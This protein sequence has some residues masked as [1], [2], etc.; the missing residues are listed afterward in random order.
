MNALA[1]ILQGIPLRAPYYPGTIERFDSFTSGRAHI[2]TIGEGSQGKLPW[3]LVSDID[4]DKADDQ[5]F[6][7][8]SF[9][10]VLGETA[11]GSSDPYHF[12]DKAVEFANERLWG[13]LSATLVLH[14]ALAKDRKTSEAVERAIGHLRYGTVSV[15]AFTGMSF[16]F[17]SPPWGAYPGSSP[18]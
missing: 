15:N 12:L 2:R 6:T 11:V 9:C 10:P 3:T 17:G 14:P 4:S 16:A 7:C 1:D 13:R 5:L 18:F 8:E